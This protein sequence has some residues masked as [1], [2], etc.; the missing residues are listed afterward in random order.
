MIEAVEIREDETIPLKSQQ[1]NIG[2]QRKYIGGGVEAERD[3]LTVIVFTRG[4]PE[5]SGTFM[6]SSDAPD[7]SE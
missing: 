5:P 7:E 2:L 4:K 6:I 1:F 3:R